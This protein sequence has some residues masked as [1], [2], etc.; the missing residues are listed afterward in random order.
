MKALPL[1]HWSIAG[2]YLHKFYKH[3]KLFESKRSWLPNDS[4]AR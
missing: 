2:L 4:L 1:A 3:K